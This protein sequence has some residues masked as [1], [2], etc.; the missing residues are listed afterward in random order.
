MLSCGIDAAGLRIM[1]VMSRPDAIV[2]Q[3]AKK[4]EQFNKQLAQEP[5]SGNC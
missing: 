4:A 1:G 3:P 5:P 2:K